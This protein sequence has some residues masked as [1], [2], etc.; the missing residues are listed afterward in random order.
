MSTWKELGIE[1]T[2]DIKEIKRAY[3]SRAK[4]CHPEE[5]PDEYQRLQTAYKWALH[6]AKKDENL[7]VNLEDMYEPIHSKK[8]VEQQELDVEIKTDGLSFD[9][10]PPVNILRENESREERFLRQV[11][12][13]IYHPY[14]RQ[15]YACWNSFMMQDENWELMKQEAVRRRFFDMICHENFIWF[16]DA[17][18]FFRRCRARFWEDDLPYNQGSINTFS[19]TEYET[20]EEKNIYNKYWNHLNIPDEEKVRKYLYD[21]LLYAELCEEKLREVHFRANAKRIEIQQRREDRKKRKNKG[22]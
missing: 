15:S 17:E 9:G 7:V 18:K 22:G 5:Y 12:Y 6:Y 16:N 1:P 11:Q 14:M 2:R 21:Y 4:Q 8:E 3:A 20:E 10:V 19:F 13:I